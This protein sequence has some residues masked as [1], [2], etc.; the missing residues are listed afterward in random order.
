MS[1]SINSWESLC[2]DEAQSNNELRH[3]SDNISIS[4]MI[5]FLISKMYAILGITATHNY[6]FFVVFN[7]NTQNQP[8]FVGYVNFCISDTNFSTMVARSC[9]IILGKQSPVASKFVLSYQ[10]WYSRLTLVGPGVL[11]NI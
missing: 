3:D 2:L 4:F 6:K 5:S 10:N 7:S 11:F 1:L 9:T 8:K